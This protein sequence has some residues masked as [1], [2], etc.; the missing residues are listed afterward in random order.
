MKYYLLTSLV[1]HLKIRITQLKKFSQ[2]VNVM[3]KKGFLI[4]IKVTKTYTD[5]LTNRYITNCSPTFERRCNNRQNG[6]TSAYTCV[7]SSRKIAY[8]ARTF[9]SATTDVFTM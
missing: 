1:N 5:N 4:Y 7:Y 6:A 2:F 8:R 9:E 3:H